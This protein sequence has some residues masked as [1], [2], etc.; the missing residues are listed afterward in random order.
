MDSRSKRLSTTSFRHDLSVPSSD[1]TEPIIS[2]PPS[3][4]KLNLT[5][6]SKRLFKKASALTQDPTRARKLTRIEKTHIATAIS[7]ARRRDAKT[8]VT[9]QQTI[10]YLRM[11]PD[12][13]CQVTETFFTKTIRFRDINYQL[14]QNDDKTAIFDGW[15]DFL[16]YFD[17]SI[18]F[19]FSCFDIK[20]LGKQLKK[21][22][23]PSNIRL[24]ELEAQLSESAEE[25]VDLKKNVSQ[26]GTSRQTRDKAQH[27]SGA[28][29]P[30]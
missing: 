3:T 24:E 7:Q 13:V 8:V 26:P 15:C 19:Q 20:E 12:G 11:F 17:S 25:A 5:R 6:R 1:R 30:T 29:A 21:L 18:R 14:A 4:G 9:A 16:N 10:P 27:R 22:G 23:M 28:K 2:M